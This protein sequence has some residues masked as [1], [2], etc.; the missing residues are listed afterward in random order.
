MIAVAFGG[1]A[2][3]DALAF[4]EGGCA[5]ADT[6]EIRID[7][8]DDAVD[9]PELVR[10][11]PCPLIITNRPPREGGRS[12]LTEA[13]RLD[14]LYAA[15]DAGAAFVDV[16]WDAATPDV[17][18]RLHAAGAATIVS[19]H[20]FDRMPA[21]I[22]R[23]ASSIEAT[24][25]AVVKVVGMARQ[26]SDVRLIL[27][28]LA[29]ARRPTIAI[30][31]GSLGRASRILALRYDACLLTF[32][33]PPTSQGTAPGQI[34]IGVLRDVYRASSIGPD[35]HAYVVA[36][37]VVSDDVM[38]AV[39]WRLGAA[40]RNAVAVPFETNEPM[41]AVVAPLRGLQIDGWR[42]TTTISV[43]DLDGIVDQ[44]GMAARRTG[45]AN[46]VVRDNGCLTAELIPP[47]FDDVA[48]FWTEPLGQTGPARLTPRS[49]RLRVP[50]P[51]NSKS[52]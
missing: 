5:E 47:G 24:G 46:A 10:R 43:A 14:T 18:S 37:S 36:G 4:L 28:V 13:A 51:S 33:A 19:R 42:F 39:N 15:A 20:E 31:M 6:V 25:A 16:E 35:T 1:P 26:T 11:S 17:I 27:D 12:S 41:R 23:W 2:M 9:V 21:E 32:A 29:R 52:T 7:L 3:S 48:R 44:L 38:T 50:S 45:Q 34:E 49:S 22:A 8:L 40:V 30:A